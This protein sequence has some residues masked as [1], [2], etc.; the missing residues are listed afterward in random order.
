MPTGLDYY[1]VEYGKRPPNHPRKPKTP[2]R[3]TTPIPLTTTFPAPNLAVAV[4]PAPGPVALVAPPRRSR[5]RGRSHSRS[6]GQIQSTSFKWHTSCITRR[7]HRRRTDI[8]YRPGSRLDWGRDIVL[9][10]IC[11]RVAEIRPSNPG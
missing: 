8:I 3:A 10:K 1:T 9:A 6:R 11:F 5:S 2:A 4:A 7:I